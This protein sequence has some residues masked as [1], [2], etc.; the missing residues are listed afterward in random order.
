MDSKYREFFYEEVLHFKNLSL[1]G[2]VGQT[3]ISVIRDNIGSNRAAT[4]FNANF[5][6]MVA[7]RL[8]LSKH[9][10]Y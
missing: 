2:I 9:Q 7:L 8:A 6:K 10:L 4:K 5:I 1:D 3:P